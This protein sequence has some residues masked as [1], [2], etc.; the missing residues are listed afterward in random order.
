M[1]EYESEHAAVGR[2]P[3]VVEEEPA[4]AAHDAPAVLSGRVDAVAPAGMARL[5]RAAGN[6]ALASSV[7]RSSVERASVQRSSVQ[8]VISQRGR[9]LP[10]DVREPLERGFGRS[11]DHVQLHD[12]P[13]ALSSARDVGAYAYASGDHI[14]VPPGAPL[15]TYAEETEHTFQQRSGPVAG[16]PDGKGHLVSDPSD[17]FEVAA[18]DRANQVLAAAQAGP[19]AAMAGAAAGPAVQRQALEDVEVQRQVTEPVVQ[20]QVAEEEDLEEPEAGA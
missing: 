4:V 12:D 11:L 3:E 2:R 18:R 9:G 14:V 19:V 17:A 1:H 6:A 16:T 15:E 10:A 5:Q 7:Q 20:R 13:A 8:E